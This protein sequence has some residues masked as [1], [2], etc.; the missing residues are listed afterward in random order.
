MSVAITAPL[1]R[2]SLRAAF[3][4]V[5]L[6]FLTATAT[7]IAVHLLLYAATSAL[8]TPHALPTFQSNGTAGAGHRAWSC[9]SCSRGKREGWRCS[10]FSRAHTVEAVVGGPTRAM[11]RERQKSCHWSIVAMNVSLRSSPHAKGSAGIMLR[12]STGD[13]LLP[14]AVAS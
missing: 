4:T 3:D 5:Q 9:E 10:L 6:T 11:P 7:P 14:G 2:A 13:L 1:R 8:S 12:M